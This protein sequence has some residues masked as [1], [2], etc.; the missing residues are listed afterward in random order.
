MEPVGTGV[1]KL[2][3]TLPLSMCA[4]LGPGLCEFARPAVSLP[5]LDLSERFPLRPIYKGVPR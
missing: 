3:L 5:R 2:A 1:S 4:I